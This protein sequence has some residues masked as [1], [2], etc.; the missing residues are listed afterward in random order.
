MHD[1]YKAHFLPHASRYLRDLTDAEKGAIA[2]D[3]DAMRDGDLSVP[4][5]KQLRGAVRELISGH[6][7]ITYAIVGSDIYFI[8]GFRK[9]TG[10]TPK[11]EIDYAVDILKSV[12]HQ[13]LLE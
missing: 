13:N 10:K 11:S 5:T 2:A 12:K 3:I 7:R 9:K 4:T 6:H 1:R 8:R